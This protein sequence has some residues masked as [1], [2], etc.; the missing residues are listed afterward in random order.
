MNPTIRFLSLFDEQARKKIDR[1][2]LFVQAVNHDFMV[3]FEDNMGFENYPEL[4][5]SPDYDFPYVLGFDGIFAHFPNSTIVKPV[6]II[7]EL[8][9]KQIITAEGRQYHENSTFYEKGLLT[10]IDIL[11]QLKVNTQKIDAE[12]NLHTIITSYEKL[13]DR[14]FLAPTTGGIFSRVFLGMGLSAFSLNFRKS[15]RFYHEFIKFRAEILRNDIEGLV[16]ATQGKGKVV[17]FTDDIAYKGRTIIPPERFLADFGKYYKEINK[18]ISDAG[19]IPLIHTDGDI[20][21]MVKAFQEVGFRGLQG[22]EGGC[23]PVYIN[24]HFPEFVVIGF[25]DMNEILPF[26][27]PHQIENHVKMLMAALKENRHYAAGPSSVINATMPIEN[28]RFFVNMVKKHGS[29]LK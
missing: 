27:T 12:K 18:I 2:P 26:G 16:N 5:N 21:T 22:W 13:Q 29:Y 28:I 6:E 17:F 14:L 15:T 10:S 9:Q 25:A 24:E 4:L 8:G 20:T 19:M 1:V 23:D 3:R 7:N 11:D